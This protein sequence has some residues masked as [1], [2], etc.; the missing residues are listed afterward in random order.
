MLAFVGVWL[1]IV[2][3][4][5]AGSMVACITVIVAAAG[6]AWLSFDGR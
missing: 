2:I 5:W 6:G 4:Q 3:Q 1:Y